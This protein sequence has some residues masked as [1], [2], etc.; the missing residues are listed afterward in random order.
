MAC[1]MGTF[2]FCFIWGKTPA[3]PLNDSSGRSDFLFLDLVAYPPP[4]P[5]AGVPLP[6]LLPCV[7]SSARDISFSFPIRMP[8]THAT[9]IDGELR[10]F[11]LVNYAEIFN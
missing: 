7:H 6:S 3:P 9:L 4:P 8:G 5:T 1:V 11:S 2:F 10:L